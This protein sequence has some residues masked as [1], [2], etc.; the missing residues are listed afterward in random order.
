MSAAD[1]VSVATMSSD[2]IIR[3][4][5]LKPGAHLDL[6]GAY[7]PDMREADDEAIRRGRLFVDYRGTTIEHI[8]ELM[9]PLKTGVIGEADVLGDLYDLVAGNTRPRAAGDITVYKN[10]GGAHLDLM[11]ARAILALPA[12]GGSRFGSSAARPTQGRAAHPLG[13]VALRQ[14]A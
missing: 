14:G 13:D 12:D 9:I 8:G 10:G 7:T 1:V 3:G 5:R 6:V 4:A 11:T 2:P